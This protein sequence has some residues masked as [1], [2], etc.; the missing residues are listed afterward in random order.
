MPMY[1]STSA[2]IYKIS[3]VYILDS[4]G[5]KVF[6]NGNYYPASNQYPNNTGYYTIIFNSSNNSVSF[7]KQ[8]HQYLESSYNELFA[9]AKSLF[10]SGNTK[11]ETAKAYT[12]YV[13]IINHYDSLDNFASATV[14]RNNAI[15][16][17]YQISGDTSNNALIIVVTISLVSLVAVGG[18]FFFRKRKEY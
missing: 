4:Q 15:L 1:Q 12:R 10:T 17:P 3:D 6:N 2:N 18:Y 8:N 9:S 11:T 14:S 16:P 5:F 13:H 7:S